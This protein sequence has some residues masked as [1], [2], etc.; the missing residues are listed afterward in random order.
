MNQFVSNGGCIVMVSSEMPEIL[1]VADRIIVMREGKITGEL[2]GDEA[3]EL[4][5]IQLA[6]F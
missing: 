2:S 4:K 6:S 5:L 1:G 3:T